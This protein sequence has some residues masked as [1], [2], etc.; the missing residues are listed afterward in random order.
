MTFDELPI[1]VAVDKASRAI[2]ERIADGEGLPLIG[3]DEW[4]IDPRR[5]SE[6]LAMI[7]SFLQP[8]EAL[9][10]P[11]MRYRKASNDKLRLMVE[12]ATLRGTTCFF[13]GRGKGECSDDVELDRIV[14]GSR[15]GTYELANCMITCG[16][17]NRDRKD[18]TI[19]AYLQAEN[20]GL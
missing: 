14:P 16:R 17:H 13:A 8:D 6:L 5:R 12:V 11:W 3:S 10:R 15:G 19:E 2:E 1:Y 7:Q 9:L 4:I 18:R 20:G